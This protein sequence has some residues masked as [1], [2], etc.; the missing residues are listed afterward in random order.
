M[1]VLVLMLV[2]VVDVRDVVGVCV[3]HKFVSL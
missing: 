3:V 2:L 1:L